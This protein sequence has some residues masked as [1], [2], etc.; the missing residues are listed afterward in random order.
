MSAERAVP[1]PCPNDRAPSVGAQWAPSTHVEGATAPRARQR[2]AVIGVHGGAPDPVTADLRRLA[3]LAGAADDHDMSHPRLFLVRHGETDWNAEGRLLSFTDAPLNAR[4]EAQAAALASAVARV[5]WDHAVSSPLVR[6][7]RT[8][9]LILSGRADRPPLEVDD[10][11]REVDFGPYEGW[12]EAQLEADPLAVSRRRDGAQLSGVESDE[13]VVLRARSFLASLDGA[14]GT[15]LVVGHG[16]MLRILI[17]TALGLP[18]S[19]ARSLRMRNCRPAVLEPGA[20]P[21]LLAL[22]AGD[23]SFEAGPIA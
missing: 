10:R 15:T 20:T 1:R 5:S 2:G 18:P 8:A 22:N 21:L 19:F 13:D 3:R 6:A 14:P 23:P 16:R 9:E 11:L 7:R 12:S 17:A 4:G